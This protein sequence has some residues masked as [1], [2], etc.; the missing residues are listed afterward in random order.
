ADGGD[1]VAPRC[2][3]GTGEHADGT[4]KPR[5]RALAFSGEEPLA[6]EGLLEPLER[7]QMLAEP[8]ALE[9]RCSKRELATAFEELGV[10]LDVQLLSVD[11]IEPERI[12]P[13]ARDR[14]GKRGAGQRVLEGEED[15]TPGVIAPELA[16]LALDPDLRELLQ[17]QADAA[18]EARDRE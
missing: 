4:W 7:R 6:R 16:E 15:G 2:C 1:D 17:P 3:I 12:E 14:R 9:R 10:T 8:E 13:L 18:I 5:Q 11:E